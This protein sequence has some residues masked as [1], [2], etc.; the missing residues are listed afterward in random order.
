MKEYEDQK[1]RTLTIEKTIY[2]FNELSTESKEQAIEKWYD[3]HEQEIQN[4]MFSEDTKMCL[5]E[6]FSNVSLN[7]SLSYSQGDGLSFTFD[8]LHSDDI[9]TFFNDIKTWNA[10]KLYSISEDTKKHIQSL[11]KDFTINKKLIKGLDLYITSSR[12]SSQY[13]HINSVDIE[14]TTDFYLNFNKKT[15]DYIDLL[16]KAFTSIYNSICQ[17]LEN[18]GY[19]NFEY[20]MNNE[21]FEEFTSSNEYQFLQDGT[22]YC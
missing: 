20:R 3:E 8:T 13:Y 18:D 17:Q 14:C 11:V 16:Q 7:Y 5:S 2:N 9:I 6:L 4:D 19:S 10:E 1:M 22:L 21:E 12:N 15:N